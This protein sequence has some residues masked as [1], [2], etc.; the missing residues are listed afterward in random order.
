MARP[1]GE[2]S[3]PATRPGN[4]AIS[5]LLV[6]TG[7][8][9][10]GGPSPPPAQR[11]AR[12]SL[13]LPGQ[14]RTAP[15]A[16]LASRFRANS[17]TRLSFPQPK[18]NHSC[19]SIA[20]GFPGSDNIC[21]MAR[22]DTAIVILAAGKGTRMRS[23]LAKVLH[24]A[25]GRPLLAHVIHACRPCKP[26]QLL[27][28]VGHQAEEVGAL[29]SELGA[30]TILQKPQ[31]GTG[32]ALQVARRAIRARSKLAIVLPGDAPLLRAETLQALVET[33]CRGE[34][35]ATILT[36]EVDDP[37]GY[38]RIVRDSEGRV[39]AIVEESSLTP[40]QRAIR[41]VNSSIYCFT[42]GK[43]WPSLNAVRPENAHHELYLTDAIGLLRERNERVLAEVV[44][45][46]AEIL[47]C[48]TRVHLAEADRV[49]RARKA[50][51][52]M[53]SGVTIYLPETVVI[54]PEVT[55]GSDTLVEPG[56]RLLGK[57]RIG[58]RC[59]IRTGSVLDD[60][61]I[62]DDAVVEAYSIL[63]SCRVG[64]RAQIGPFARLR[65]ATDVRAGAHV[66]SFVEMKNTVLH[67]DA[68]APHL[69]YLGDASI[70]RDTNIGA[71]TITCNYDGVAKHATT[72]GRG[73]FIGSDTALV[74]PL[75]IGDGA[76]IAAGSV[77]TD[78]VPPDALAIARGRQS[79][80]PGWAA[81]RRKEIKRTRGS[82]VSGRG[83][84]PPRRPAPGSRPQARSRR[85]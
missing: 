28:V 19:V 69:S 62:D 85:R 59:R 67:E 54:D 47:G 45:D 15:G 58:A 42:L 71:G 57:T 68:K 29:A 41:E 6:S 73:V 25:G 37:T 9:L 64:K 84:K 11:A 48:N 81:R 72:I 50:T 2:Y 7:S 35:A 76:Y 31:R 13:A 16:P 27:V 14:P 4:S 33:H 21:A 44:L 63:D 24:L 83:R 77:L 17:D 34:A 23:E 46:S 3:F 74:A 65:P 12:P 22:I 79:N 20:K 10:S 49:L 56:V 82:R 80:K 8:R 5:A 75:R 26:A 43:L 66:G 53:E 51:E 60:A 40:E 18:A 1:F 39:L 61:R 52:L 32:H 70:G 36:A 78:N 30:K 38:G 55:A